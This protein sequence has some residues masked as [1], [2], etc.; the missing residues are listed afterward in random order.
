MK[1]SLLA[2]FLV[3]LLTA[4][5][6]SG[7]VLA[8]GAI[9]SE[10]PFE[11]DI[12]SCSGEMI[13]LSGTATWVVRYEDLG[14]GGWRSTSHYSSHGTAVGQTTGTVYR[15]NVTN[16]FT[17][18]G[19]PS[20]PFPTIS[21]GRLHLRLIAEGGAPD[22]YLE[23]NFQH[24]TFNPEGALVSYTYVENLRCAGQP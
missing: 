6:G 19:K 21:Q 12:V 20:A 18:F 2:T 10:E 3:L 13:H 24:Y 4:F 16:N 22:V 14:D 17:D 11:R 8:D 7:L 23:L 15:W 1:R 9:T 5:V